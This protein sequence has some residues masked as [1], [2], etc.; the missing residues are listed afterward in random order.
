M[1]LSDVSMRRVEIK[2]QST[3]GVPPLVRSASVL[4]RRFQLI[5]ATMIA[6]A[7]AGEDVVQLE[8]GALVCLEIEPGIDQRHLAEAMGIGPSNA[9]LI[10]NRLQ[11]K[12]LIERR[13][14]YD[15]RRARELY[16][17]PKGRAIWRRLRRKANAANDQVLAPLMPNQRELFLDC[18]ARIIEGNRAY[19]RPGAG[20]RKRV[21]QGADKYIRGLS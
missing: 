16:L 15:D 6:D 11:S 20:R 10:V 1:P 9:S 7:L 19:A 13:I 12:G 2:D 4:V 21:S 18:L 3:A 5:C 14:N 8:Y 17:K